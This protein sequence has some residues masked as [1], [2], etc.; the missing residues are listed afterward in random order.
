MENMNGLY[1]GLLL[2]LAGCARNGPFLRKVFLEEAPVNNK[3][4]SVYNLFPLT[5][6][7]FY[8]SKFDTKT[9]SK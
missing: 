9:W 3:Y 4:N 6:K 1:F 2:S 8:I 5:L 7:H